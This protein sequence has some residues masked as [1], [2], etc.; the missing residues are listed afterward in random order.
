MNIKV[1]NLF[2]GTGNIKKGTMGFQKQMG[3]KMRKAICKKCHQLKPLTRHSL[4]GNH[5][6]PFKLL[7]RECHD[8]EH[9]IKPNKVKRF[10]RAHKKYAIGTKRQHKRK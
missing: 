4:I 7:C 10:I 8:K 6:P 1:G 5:Q 9:G 3:V 2:I